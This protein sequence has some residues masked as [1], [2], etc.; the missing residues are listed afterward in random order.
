MKN[1][2]KDQLAQMRQQGMTNRE[3]AGATGK[4]QGTI[5]YLF[6][7][8]KLCRKRSLITLEQIKEFNR[9]KQEGM[10]IKEI[11]EKT[12]YPEETVYY[13]LKAEKAGSDNFEQEFPTKFAVPRKPKMEKVVYFGIRYEDITEIYIPT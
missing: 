4:S 9:M 7:K 3:I 2:T 6:R 13:H 1:P 5:E 11:A 8:Y 12:G 10:T